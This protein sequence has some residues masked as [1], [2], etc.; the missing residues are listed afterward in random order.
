MD[1]LRQENQALRRE[2]AHLRQVDAERQ[3]TVAALLEK[4]EIFQEQIALLKKALFAPRRERFIPSPD[5][6]LL[7]EGQTWETPE[8]PSDAGSSAESA[9]DEE[10]KTPEELQPDLAPRKP[11]AKRKR[12]EFPQCLPVKRIEY[13]LPDAERICPCG[14]GQRAVIREQITRQL[15]YQRA[16]AY[17]AEHVRYLY[18]CP[19]NRTGQELITSEKSPSVN[20]KGVLGAS[21]VAWLAQSKFE[22][23]L[24]L[25]RLQE[26]LHAASRMWFSRSVLSGALLRTAARLRPLVDLICRQILQ[27]FY[28]RVD[29]TT[30]RV[31]RPGTGKTDQVYLWVYVGDEQHPYQFFDYR[32]DRTRAGPEAILKGFQGGLLSDGHSAYT[33]LIARSADRLFDLGCWAHARRKFDESCAV[34]SHPLAEEALAWIWLLYDLEDRYAEVTAEERRQVRLRES[35][36][37]L[38]R[39]HEQLVEARPAVRPSSKLAEAIGYVLNR[40]E[41]M[42]RFTTDG[43][44]AIDNNA[45]ERSLRPSVIGRKNY[46]FFGS[47]RGGEAGCIWYTLIQSARDNHVCVL[48][49]LHD[50][51]LQV[52]QIVPEYLRVGDAETAFDSLSTEQVSALTSLLP[53]RWLA[54]HPEHRSEDRQ[55][56]LELEKQ[57]RRQRRRLRRPIKI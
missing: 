40:W 22:R 56:E 52:P 7:F 3:A 31:L 17:V 23:H 41:G 19:K 33:A 55:R 24:P 29:E 32:L 10:A 39:L 21:V 48:P 26:E 2:V 16:S 47:D 13:P 12:F 38:D 34:T 9:N 42:T 53:D 5:Q 15:E 6:K 50:V 54:T 27:S 46:E 35:V 14:C 43:R 49:Y 4:L 11:R 28:L 37:L 44:Y 36:P 8:E 30:A 18:G 45:A 25:Y 51:L 1:S 57:R 20:D